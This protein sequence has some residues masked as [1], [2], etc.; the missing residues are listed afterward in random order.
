MTTNLMLLSDLPDEL[1]AEIL[2]KVPAKSLVKLKTTC[3]GWYCLFRDPKFIEKNKKLGKAVRESML[4]YSFRV[5]SISEDLHGIYRSGVEP[6]IKFTGGKLISVKFLISKIFHLEGLIL[7][8]NKWNTRL[9]V[10]NP[11]CLEIE[12]EDETYALLMLNL[13]FTK[14]VDTLIYKTGKALKGRKHDEGMMISDTSGFAIPELHCV[15]GFGSA[16]L[17]Y[18]DQLSSLSSYR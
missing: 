14:S 13:R 6:S 11:E 2:S 10:W 18:S 8:C 12:C 16:P 3:K 7:C 5:Y 1:E 17:P 15:A 4:L 9:A